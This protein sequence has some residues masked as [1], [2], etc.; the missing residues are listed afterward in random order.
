VVLGPSELG[1]LSGSNLIYPLSELSNVVT[2]TPSSSSVPSAGF[3]AHSAFTPVFVSFVFSSP[4]SSSSSSSSSFPSSSPFSSFFVLAASAASCN[5]LLSASAAA[6]ITLSLIRF[7]PKKARFLLLLDSLPCGWWFIAPEAAAQLPLLRPEVEVL[8]AFVLTC[9]RWPLPDIA[10]LVG[11][12]PSR[13]SV[14][15]LVLLQLLVLL[16]R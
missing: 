8:L 10:V 1:N 7:E 5:R 9:L 15:A 12:T 16:L 3:A 4:P 6:S 14:L 13:K 11:G 2:C